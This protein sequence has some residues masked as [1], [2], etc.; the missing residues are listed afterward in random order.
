MK[1]KSKYKIFK[2]FDSKAKAEKY[3]DSLCVL[4]GQGVNGDAISLK[5]R[6][7][8]NRDKTRY[9]VR[10]LVRRGSK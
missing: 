7:W 10:Q 9:Y 5:T 4:Y 6:K 2:G 8:T 1:W 3:F